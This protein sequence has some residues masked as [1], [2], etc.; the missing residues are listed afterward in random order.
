MKENHNTFT[1][2][3]EK[4]ETI[5][6]AFS[7]MK[8]IAETSALSRFPVELYCFIALGSTSS[9]CRLLKSIAINF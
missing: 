4:P 1:V 7:I 5:S 3:F 2:L 9:F 6:F 8:N